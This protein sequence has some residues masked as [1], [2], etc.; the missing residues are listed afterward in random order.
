MSLRTWLIAAGLLVVLLALP[1]V[2]GYFINELGTTAGTGPTNTADTLA[3]MILDPLRLLSSLMAILWVFTLARLPSPESP[4]KIYAAVFLG[5]GI[6]YAIPRWTSLAGPDPGWEA[7]FWL[8]PIAT[9]TEWV[10]V[11][12]PLAGV[13]GIAA[14]HLLRTVPE[15]EPVGIRQR[16]LNALDVVR[17]R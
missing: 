13:L 15:P 5:S 12:A 3:G 4:A 11:H 2:P 8:I 1:P 7:V 14:F 17:G 10:E 6:L 16:I 9:V